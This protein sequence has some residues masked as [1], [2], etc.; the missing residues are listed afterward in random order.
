MSEDKVYDSVMITAEELMKLGKVLDYYFKGENIDGHKAYFMMDIVCR[1][2]RET[3]KM[4]II[5]EKMIDRE[6]LDN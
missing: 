6:D 2:F 5:S 4:E 3:N 1:E